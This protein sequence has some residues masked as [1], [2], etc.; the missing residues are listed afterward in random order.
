MLQEV[1]KPL[2]PRRK[3]KLIVVN[4]VVSDPYLAL[5][6]AHGAPTPDYIP[7]QNV[8]PH[9]CVQADQRE[10]WIGA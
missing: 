10:D 1:V 5:W 8:Q 4:G 7:F 2:A 9:E 6:L 3:A